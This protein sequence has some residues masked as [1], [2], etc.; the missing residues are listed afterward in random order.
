MHI[1]VHIYIYIHT[2]ISYE[3]LFIYSYSG[4]SSERHAEGARPPRRRT[5]ISAMFGLLT[6]Q[7]VQV[8]TFSL[9]KYH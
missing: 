5:Y 8:L 1:I 7:P 2:H 9:M 4:K 3:I 6:S